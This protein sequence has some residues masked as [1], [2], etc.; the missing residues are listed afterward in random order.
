MNA[1]ILTRGRELTATLSTVETAVGDLVADLSVPEP[2]PGRDQQAA[3][4][5]E[6][7]LEHLQAA[8]TEIATLAGVLAQGG[9]V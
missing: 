4:H 7:A 3:I 9:A 5:S 6:R 1:A 8:R 2:W